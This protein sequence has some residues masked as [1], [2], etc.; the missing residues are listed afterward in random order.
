MLDLHGYEL[1]AEEKEI[2][3]HPL[4]GGIILFSRNY[5]DRQQLQALIRQIRA[6]SRQHLLLAVDQE[7]GRVQ[8]FRHQFTPLPA[9]QSFALC[10]SESDALRL[11]R[12][13]GWLMAYELTSLDIDISFAPVL[14][15]GHQSAA[16]GDRAFHDN[17]DDVIKLASHFIEGMHQAGMRAT[18]KHFP[19][20]GAVIADSHLETPIDNRTFDELN[21][22]DLAVFRQLIKSNLLDGIM[23]AH[24]IYAQINSNPA[25]GSNFWIKQVLRQQLGFKGI[26]FSD[27][28]SMEGAAIMGNY[29]Q[30]AK[31]AMHAGCDILLI[32]NQRQGAISVLDSL[33]Q[34]IQIDLSN[35][36]QRNLQQNFYQSTRWQ[37]VNKELTILNERWQE[38]K[39]LAKL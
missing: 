14:D 2:I 26:V 12:D 32:C 18:G 10:N 29:T 11:A 33:P 16:I 27:D 36:F 3:K 30:R 37:Q 13:A 20:H 7:G 4:V 1:D 31:S 35:L 28:L 22:S 5:Y 23:P 15:V 38:Y 17:T 34:T 19:G 39:Q 9:A 8:R 25:S 24:V 21:R 6:E